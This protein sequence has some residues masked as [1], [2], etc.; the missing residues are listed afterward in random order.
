VQSDEFIREV[1]EELQRDRLRAVW[2]R[3]GAVIVGLALLAVLAVA[4]SEGWRWWQSR[5]RQAESLRYAAAEQLLTAGKPGEA[6]T[7]FAAIA[8]DGRTGYAALARLRQAAALGAAKNEAGEEQALEQLASTPGADPLL[9]ELAVLLAASHEVDDGDPKALAERLQ[10]LAAAGQ[11]WRD[12]ARELLALVQIRA[13]DTVKARA[14]LQELTQD[15]GVAPA[16]Q[17]RAQALLGSIGG[18][19]QPAAATAATQ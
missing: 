6:A 8:D 17:K 12:T 9:Q 15:V 16:Q 13:G 5:V 2:K 7:A 11:P 3:Y 1:N 18:G 4:A 14:T 10:P 19:D